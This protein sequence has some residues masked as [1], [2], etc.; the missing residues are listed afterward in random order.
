MKQQ[1][2]IF[3][4]FAL[5]AF[6]APFLF[7]GGAAFFLN[8][9][10]ANAGARVERLQPLSARDLERT[11]NGREVLVEG[12][13]RRRQPDGAALVRRLRAR[14]TILRQQKRHEMV[15]EGIGQAAAS[16]RIA[17]RRGT[18]G[19]RRLFNRLR[20]A[21]RTKRQSALQRFSGGRPGNGGRRGQ[22]RRGQKDNRRRIYHCP[23]R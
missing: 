14:R 2:R 20:A 21:R 22:K 18:I 8:N 6:S 17:G 23:G 19:K 3:L 15:G 7:L 11:A 5:A 1:H 4:C 13:H 12:T 9:L 10:A 16:N